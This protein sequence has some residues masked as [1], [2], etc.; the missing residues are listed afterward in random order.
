MCYILKPFFNIVIGDV[1]RRRKSAFGK[2]VA[3][4]HSSNGMRDPLASRAHSSKT[5]KTL[6]QL[7]SAAQLNGSDADQKAPADKVIKGG[8]QKSLL[9]GDKS[10][11]IP[12]IDEVMDS[13]GNILSP[14]TPTNLDTSVPNDDDLQIT[15]KLSQEKVSTSELDG[16]QP[17]I[18]NRYAKRSC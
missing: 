12:F 9:N 5:R 3:G 15:I 2:D 14:S 4:S 11:D 13:E 16:D 18:A 1:E 10:K 17:E 7:Q 8:A 6:V